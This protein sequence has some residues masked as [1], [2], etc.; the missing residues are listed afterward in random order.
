MGHRHWRR[1][2]RGLAVDLGVMAVVSCSFAAPQPAPADREAAIST[3]FRD[4]RLLEQFDGIS[5]GTDEDEFGR[6]CVVLLRIDVLETHPP[7]AVVLTVQTHD[8][9]LV[10]D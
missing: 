5:T 9:M 7:S 2:L 3:T 4:A 1:P 10:M 8:A 6:H